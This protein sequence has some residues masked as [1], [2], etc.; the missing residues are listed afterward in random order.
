MTDRTFTL[1]EMQAAIE[2]FNALEAE[3][4][5]RE[6]SIE[7]RKAR[8]DLIRFTELT[9]P[10]P[11]DPEDFR[12]SRYQAAK[13]HRAIAAALE[14]VEK[15]HWLRVIVNAPPRHGKSELA[16]RRFIPWYV[17]RDPYRSVI[18][19]TYNEE[20]A[21]DFGSEVREIMRSPTYQEIFPGAALAYGSQATDRL[22]TTSGGQMVF[23][24]RG[25]SLTGRGAD[26]LLID[27]PIK[28]DKEAQS[29]AIRNQLWNWYTRVAATRLMTGA[30][31]IVIIQT[32]W[33]EDDLVG[34]LTDPLNPC[35]SAKEARKWRIIDLPALAIDN[36]PMG[37]K[38]GEPLWPERFDQEYLE[39]MREL[40]PKG[41]SAL[42]QGR[43]SPE[44]GDFFKKDYIR[45]YRP[46]QLPQNLRYY[47]AS[48]H[49]VGTDET[50]DFTCLLVAGV[51]QEDNIWIVDAWWQRA[52]TT[53]VVDAMLLFMRQ[54]PIQ[55]WWAER[56]H[57]S[58]S[59][60]PFLRK[61]MLEE[62]VYCAIDEQTPVGDKRTRAQSIQGRMAMGKVVFPEKAPWFQNAKSEMLKFDSGTHD[63]FVDALA[64]LGMGLSKQLRARKPLALAQAPREGTLGHLKWETAQRERRERLIRAAAGF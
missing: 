46:G 14:E 56:G 1:E 28:D 57:I 6:R 38:P 25:G 18:M 33:H 4:R 51:D 22:K 55:T 10:H 43:P 21:R 11:D 61:R 50:H 47:A 62:K 31:R 59:I 15:G 2:Q 34:R 26:L 20:F 5:R 17:G 58:K 27:D 41:F 44:E 19:G 36:D 16:D 53:T 24:G 64:H 23:V 63:D 40:D 29:P 42:Y 35:Y 9:M 45:T 32:R 30:G 3:I 60:G 48:D 52:I 49:A 7:A 54:Y 39:S 8:D 37:R 12:M 13:H